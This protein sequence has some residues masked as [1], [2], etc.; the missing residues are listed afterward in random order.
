MTPPPTP[1]SSA[2]SS[3]LSG[4][5]AGHIPAASSR[6]LHPGCWRQGRG[7]E[8]PPPTSRTEGS[9][10][11]PAREERRVS[12]LFSLGALWH[13]PGWWSSCEA[14]AL[15]PCSCPG[16]SAIGWVVPELTALR[17]GNLGSFMTLGLSPG[18][19]SWGHSFQHSAV[20]WLSQA[21]FLHP[22]LQPSL[23]S[24]SARLPERAL[25]GPRRG[26]SLRLLGL[27]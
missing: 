27:P 12:L 13:E 20:R 14:D 26:A 6:A 1:F 4:P 2:P 22:G 24:L 18:A 11:R 19:Y 5:A 23:S 10:A 8:A 16:I 3:V 25:P 15:Q 17:D 21:S 7:W 9:L